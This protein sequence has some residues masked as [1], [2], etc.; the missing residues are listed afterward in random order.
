MCVSVW[1]RYDSGSPKLKEPAEG[2][3]AV[4]GMAIAEVV[5]LLL[6][7][8]STPPRGSRLGLGCE[9]D[10]DKFDSTLSEVITLLHTSALE[11]ILLL[12]VSLAVAVLRSVF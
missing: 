11:T 1:E 10:L 2:S 6:L 7:F 5:E 3:L 8:R 12:L 9:D 4:E